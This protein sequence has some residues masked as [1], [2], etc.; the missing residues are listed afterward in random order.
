MALLMPLGEGGVGSD[1]QVDLE[2]LHQPIMKVRLHPS[3]KL[4]LGLVNLYLLVSDE[5]NWMELIVL[6]LILRF[7]GIMSLHPNLIE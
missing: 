4:D 3:P 6:D 2:Y 5:G 1:L 7:G